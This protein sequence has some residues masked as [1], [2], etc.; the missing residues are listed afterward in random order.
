MFDVI[1]DD[2]VVLLKVVWN[3]VERFWIEIDD[4]HT[5]DILPTH[6]I[7]QT[8][9]SIRNVTTVVMLI[10]IAATKQTFKLTSPPRS[11]TGSMSILCRG[12]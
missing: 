9:M 2:G 11:L 5:A 1:F 10:G 7:T 8:E 3:L 12:S 4:G 6:R